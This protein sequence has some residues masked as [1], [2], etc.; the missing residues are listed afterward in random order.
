MILSFRVVETW[1]RR[2]KE[3]LAGHLQESIANPPFVKISSRKNRRFL[4]YSETS[5]ETML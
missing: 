2:E 4:V 3:E 1:T 5:M